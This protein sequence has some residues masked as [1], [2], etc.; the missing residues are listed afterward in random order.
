[1]NA[2]VTTK[3]RKMGTRGR[4]DSFTP[5]MFMTVRSNTPKSGEHELVRK[6]GR[7]KKAEQG[8]GAA[9]HG[10]RDRQHVVDQERRARDHARRGRQQFAR[11]EITAAAGREELDDLRVARGDDEDRDP[12]HERDEDAQVDVAVKGEE[13]FL[14]AVTGRGKSV[15]AQPDPGEEG[16][17]RELVEDATCRRCYAC[18]RG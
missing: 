3:V 9:R 10:N 12:R 14:R 4:T 18:R 13:G 1:M 11:D 6:P 17:E 2:W 15:G 7:G 8:I 5:R 16:D